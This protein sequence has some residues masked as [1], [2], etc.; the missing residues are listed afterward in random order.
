MDSD[1]IIPSESNKIAVLNQIDALHEEHR[2]K[3]LRDLATKYNDDLIGM[4]YY[5][6]HIKLEKYGNSAFDLIFSLWAR[7]IKVPEGLSFGEPYDDVFSKASGPRGYRYSVK[8][9]RPVILIQNP[10]MVRFFLLMATDFVHTRQAINSC[11]GK[12]RQKDGSSWPEIKTRDQFRE[13]L[14]NESLKSM[15]LAY[16]ALS[17]DD[18]DMF[19]GN[20]SIQDIE[21]Y[22]LGQ[23]GYR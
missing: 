16:L 5:A 6:K 18:K 7:G 17:F 14:Q 23:M 11:I 19:Y 8:Y 22:V 20:F 3:I 13:F 4:S 1:L 9:L 2:L 15:E 10:S 21:Y 12:L